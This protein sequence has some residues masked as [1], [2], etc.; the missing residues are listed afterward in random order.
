MEA[1]RALGKK[2]MA[3]LLLP[4]SI[5]AFLL[6]ACGSDPVPAPCAGAD[7][8]PECELECVD[9]PDCPDRFHC[10]PGGTCTAECSAYDG[11]CGSGQICDLDGR[12]DTEPDIE[13]GCGSLDVALTPVE[14]TVILLVDRSGSM[15][16][17]FGGSDRWNAVKEALTDPADGVVAQLESQVTFGATLYN[18]EGGDAGGTCPILHSEP[19]A[20]G[21]AAGIRALFEAHDPDRDTP[22][23]ESVAA[24]AASFPASDDPR[25][26]VLATDG[27]PDNCDDPDAHD[28]GSQTGSETAV[29]SAY[30]GGIE[31]HVL[32]VG[33]DATASHLQR[34]ANAGRG[35]PLDSGNAPFYVA[36]DSQELVDAFGEIVRGVRGCQLAIDGLIDPDLA[37]GG[38]VIFNGTELKFGTEWRLLDDQTIEL[39]GAACDALLEADQIAVKA[40]FPCPI[41]VD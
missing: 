15:T 41:E 40:V 9:D 12:C 35:L 24:V 3:R 21:T 32:S 25:I 10:G 1:R 34:V 5:L 39:I 11:Q 29:E 7:P 2:L 4:V 38:I 16:E 17:G 37:P 14:P 19:P 31:T 20:R 33:S 27:N 18:S 22:T 30:A 8:A 13:N 23:A 26:I 28:Q 36:N 6:A